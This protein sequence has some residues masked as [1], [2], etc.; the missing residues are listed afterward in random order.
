MWCLTIL[1]AKGMFGRGK[2]DLYKR[3]VSV[4][5]QALGQLVTQILTQDDLPVSL[6]TPQKT[7]RRLL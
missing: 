2:F 7:R 6:F 1:Q 3:N 5:L 4:L